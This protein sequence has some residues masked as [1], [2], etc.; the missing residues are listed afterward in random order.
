[1]TSQILREINSL[2]QQAEAHYTAV[3]RP[4]FTISYAQSLN[5][6]ITEKQGQ[7]TLIS[8][9]ESMR[10]AHQLRAICDGILVGVGTVL[11]DDP[12]LT[13]RLPEQAARNPTPI[14]LDSYLRTPASARVLSRGDAV[15]FTTVEKSLPNVQVIQ[16]DADEHGRID[17]PTM[18]QHLGKIGI[19]NV[20][21]EG[22]AEVLR[23]FIEQRLADYA[24]VTIAPVFIDGYSVFSAGT[25]ATIRLQD[26]IYETVGSDIVA[27]GKL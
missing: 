12:R 5:G 7:Q 23:S 22:G 6:S 27:W 16:I 24:M 17:L 14:I 4:L 1:M 26:V 13:V 21:I 9:D 10:L 15:I 2:P 3:K 18:A 19:R 8:G 20:M 25:G 11:S